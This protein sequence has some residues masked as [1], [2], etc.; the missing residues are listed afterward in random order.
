M[1]KKIFIGIGVMVVTLLTLGASD[2]EVET[3][4]PPS[5]TP[6]ATEAPAA[7]EATTSL[8]GCR[9]VDSIRCETYHKLFPHITD[10]FFLDESVEFTDADFAWVDCIATVAS[11]HL[12]PDSDQ[13]IIEDALQDGLNACGLPPLQ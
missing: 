1:F 7:I 2:C 9:V 10:V 5:E 13:A 8:A 3:G 12:F 11:E 4:T 6:S